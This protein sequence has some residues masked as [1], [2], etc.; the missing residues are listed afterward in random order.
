M[1]HEAQVSTGDKHSRYKQVTSPEHLLQPSRI[2]ANANSSICRFNEEWPGDRDHDSPVSR[3]RTTVG[4]RD[5]DDTSTIAATVA[6]KGKSLRGGNG[7][8][9]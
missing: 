3:G 9:R 2:P 4:R 8:R 6:G 7:W 5:F 1:A